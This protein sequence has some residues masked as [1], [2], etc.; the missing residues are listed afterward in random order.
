[1]PG[2]FHQGWLLRYVAGP[3]VGSIPICIDCLHSTCPRTHTKRHNRP[4]V[5]ALRCCLV[6]AVAV[7]MASASTATSSQADDTAA[8]LGFYKRHM[9]PMGWPFVL[10]GTD[11]GDAVTPFASTGEGLAPQKSKWKTQWDPST[12][13]P[14][15]RAA[16]NVYLNPRNRITV[17]RPAGN[18]TTSKTK[19][20]RAYNNMR[21]RYRNPVYDSVRPGPAKFY[22]PGT[23]KQLVHTIKRLNRAGTRWVVRGGGHS[24]DAAS[25]P[26]GTNA[27]VIDM[28]RFTQFRIASDGQSAVL[29]AGQRLGEVYLRLAQHDPPLIIVADTCAAN[30]AS[31]Y[32]LGGGVGISSRKYGYASDHVSACAKA[33]ELVRTS[34]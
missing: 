27:A 28:A 16:E 34:V 30:G 7:V 23:V 8:H 15:D 26:T 20:A 19:A 1:M 3:P 2:L 5:I 32:L 12:Y 14:K 9:S 22:M 21:L 33:I 4:R 18:W 31:G 10:A 17:K 29:G 11:G 13:N 24:Y 25:L 6:A